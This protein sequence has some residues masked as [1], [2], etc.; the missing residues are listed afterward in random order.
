MPLDHSSSLSSK[1]SPVT[2]TARSRR[3]GMRQVVKAV[4]R[5]RL[6]SR[7]RCVQITMMPHSVKRA[8]TVA[9]AAPS[10]PRAGAPSLPKIRM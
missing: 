2:A 7:W 8:M 9:M 5:K 6:L 3:P 1:G 10:T 4:F